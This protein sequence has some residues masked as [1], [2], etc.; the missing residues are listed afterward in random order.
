MES[1]DQLGVSSAERIANQCVPP[2]VRP[3]T[4]KLSAVPRTAGLGS[5]VTWV[6]PSQ[7]ADV[8]MAEVA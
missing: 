2:G 7:S 3:A 6:A 5:P 8:A 4:S 1:P